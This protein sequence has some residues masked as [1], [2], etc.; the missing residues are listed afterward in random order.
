MAKQKHQDQEFTLELSRISS[1]A[2][3][4]NN[5][6]KWGGLSF[7]SLMAFLIVRSLAGQTTIADIGV[8]ILGNFRISTAISYVFMFSGVL[9]G[10]SERELRKRTV[11]RLAKR[12]SEL[13]LQLDP[14]RSSSNLTSRGDTRPEDQ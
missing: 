3:T 7:M 6:I 9:Y 14:N 12:I 13:E 5:L 1:R 4:Q 2:N 8:N 10:A 11:E